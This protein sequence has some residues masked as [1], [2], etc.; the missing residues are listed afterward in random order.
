MD[1]K[2]ALGKV[3][4]SD[5]YTKFMEAHPGSYLAHCFQ[6]I[7][8]VNSGTWQIGFFSK[9][10]DR[11]VTFFVS[12]DEIEENPPA[13]VL[14][15]EEDVVKELDM[16]KVK[17]GFDEALVKGD[18]F[19]AEKYSA[20]TVTKKI[21]ILQHLPLGQVY[22]FTYVTASFKILNMKIDAGSGEVLEHQFNSLM[23]LGKVLKK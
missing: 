10:E 21:G 4:G 14:K 11:L 3:T 19:K 12:G 23:D 1:V 5:L 9:K 17:I 15:K 6:M 8:D 13:E 7:D 18:A 20:E 16:D 22:N 2:D